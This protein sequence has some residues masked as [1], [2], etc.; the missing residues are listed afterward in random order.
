M[1]KELQKIGK[2]LTKIARSILGIKEGTDIPATI[3]GIKKDISFRGP[4]A[5]I[6]IFSILIASIGLNV[7]SVPVI[8]GAMLISPLMGPILGVGLSIGTH[9]LPTL[10]KSLK[11]LGIAVAISLITS[12]LYFLITPLNVEQA[13][14]LARTKPTILDVMVAIFGGFV[15]IIAGSRREKSNVVPGVAIATALMP[16]LCTAG[17]GLANLN[18]FHFVGAFYLFFI[19]SVFISLSTF[20]VVKYLKFPLVTNIEEEKIK[21]YRIPFAL[22]LLIVTIPSA[23]IFYSVIQET[24]Y[25]INA[26]KFVEEKT[27]FEGSELI[28]KRITYSDTLSVID[29]FYIGETISDE[30]IIYMQE[31]LPVYNLSGHGRFPSTKKTEVRVHQEQND[32]IDFESKFKEFNNDLR[33]GILEDIYTKNQT[34]IK[35]KDLKIELLEKEIIKLQPKDTI[36]YK[37][38]DSE[39]KF[40]FPDIEKYSFSKMIEYGAYGDSIV[41]DTIPTFLIR[42]K[43]D[44][45]SWKKRETLKSINKWLPVRLKNE[46]IRGLEY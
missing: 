10:T 25:N 24:R 41:Y 21:K 11:N 15:G 27:S 33:M 30:E 18:F 42:F 14:L 6:L 32:N 39:L 26:E 28:N 23:L 43:P 9:D 8:I 3:E 13:E 17:Y 44:A 12:T 19:N 20:I 16:P 36:N 46:K 37:Q 45:N 38:I 7:N 22:F 29:L 5:W 35:D 2:A 1:R 40:H 31:F 34:V 4:S